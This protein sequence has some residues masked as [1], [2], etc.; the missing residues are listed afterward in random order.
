MSACSITAAG[1]MASSTPARRQPR[2][3]AARL[4]I[5]GPEDAGRAAIEDYIQARY[6]QRFGARIV[7]WLPTL[8]SLKAHGEIVAAAGY[9]SA[10]NPLYLERYL[11]QPIQTYLAAGESPSP[12]RSQI[13]ETGQ[14]ASDRSAGRLLVPMLAQHL[15]SNGF[16]WA[17]STVTS[18]LAHLFERMGLTPLVLGAADPACLTAAER[19]AWGT[20]YAHTPHVVAERLSRVV[21][22]LRAA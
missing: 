17:V 19:E 2:T 16:L 5:H 3:S 11:P 10:A 15:S 6:L 13:V 12:G 7:D 18:E 8:V 1:V 20:Y 21:R 14:F 9:R 22:Q 4:C